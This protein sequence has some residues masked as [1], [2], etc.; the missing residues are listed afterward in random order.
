MAAKVAVSLVQ[1]PGHTSNDHPENLGRFAEFKHL[2]EKPLSENLQWLEPAPATVEEVAAAHSPEMIKFLM[3]TCDHLPAGR[4]VIIDPAPT[5]VVSASWNA[6][7]AAA[8]GALTVTRSVTKGEVK[9]GFALV[10][11]PG[12]HATREISMG[13]CLLNNLAIAVTDSLARER[14]RPFRKVAI[15]D[16]DAHH[17]NG[18][19]EIFRDQPQVGFFSLHQEGIYP[20]SGAM[21]EAAQARGRLIN[22]PLPA[23]SGDAAL[24]KISEQVIGPW[25]RRFE[26]ELLFVSA[27]FDGHWADPLTSLG[28]STTGFFNLVSNLVSLAEELCEG[29]VVCIL[30]GGYDPKALGNNV[31]AVLNALVGNDLISDPLGRSPWPEPDIQDRLNKL[32]DLHRI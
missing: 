32:R 25:L 5:Y 11:P 27:G 3:T 30:E 20:G 1:S 18:T 8:G 21:D 17:G 22:L 2:V 4:S 19:E 14:A 6:A 16:F 26:P 28:F 29:R 13:F 12:H 23:Y 24:L 7:L 31:E 10:R 9:R 15:V